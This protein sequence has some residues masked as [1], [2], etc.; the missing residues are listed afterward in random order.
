MRNAFLYNVYHEMKQRCLNPRC[1]S[2]PRYGGR[3]I[4]VCPEWTAPNGVYTFQEWALAAGWQEGLTLDRRDNDGDYTPDNCRFVTRAENLRNRTMTPAWR[5][6]ILAAAAI[7]RRSMTPKRLEA[8]RA[9]V[10]KARQARSDAAE[11]R[12]WQTLIDSP[13]PRGV[14]LTTPTTAPAPPPVRA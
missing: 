11:D 6:A 14:K 3:G 10:A 13:D 1:K 12:A 2:W 7:G 8:C 9:N 4:K 5:A